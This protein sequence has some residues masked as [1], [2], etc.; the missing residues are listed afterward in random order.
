L[1]AQ[2]AS[3]LR[4]LREALAA[5]RRR[6]GARLAAPA[7]A[8]AA[9]ALTL[10]LALALAAV[11]VPPAVLGDGCHR[12]EAGV[13]VLPRAQVLLR[14]ALLRALPQHLLAPVGA[15]GQRERAARRGVVERPPLEIMQ[16]VRVALLLRRARPVVVQVRHVPMRDI[17]RRVGDRVQQLA[18][19]AAARCALGPLLAAVVADAVVAQVRRAPVELRLALGHPRQALLASLPPLLRLRR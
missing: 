4:D 8:L 6:G 5:G 19:E 18:R 15:L 16:L 7:A 9:L 3:L 17:V 11:L 2:R 13:Q 12:L 10:A 14:L 1:L